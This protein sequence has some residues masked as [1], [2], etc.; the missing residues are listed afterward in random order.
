MTTTHRLAP[1]WGEIVRGAAAGAG[2]TLA[3]GLVTLGAA[4]VL[5]PL[6]ADQVIG[7]NIGLGLGLLAVR[8]VG[9][10]LLAWWLVRRLGVPRPGLATAAGLVVYLLLA[11]VSPLDAAPPGALF[12]WT[13]QGGLAGALGVYIAGASVARGDTA[14]V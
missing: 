14:Q 6:T 7:A 2:A 1:R 13:V 9:T 8:L 12:A 3:V 11:A 10:M 4:A 5:M